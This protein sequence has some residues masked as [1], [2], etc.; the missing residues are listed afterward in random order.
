MHAL[1]RQNP[2]LLREVLASSAYESII[3]VQCYWLLYHHSACLLWHNTTSLSHRCRRYRRLPTR[4]PRHSCTWRTRRCWSRRECTVHLHTHPHLE[5]QQ[6]SVFICLTPQKQYACLCVCVCLC[7]L[8]RPAVC[9]EDKAWVTGAGIRSGDISA[10]L[11]A[12]TIATF[13]NIWCKKKKRDK[14]VMKHFLATT[15]LSCFYCRWPEEGAVLQEE[16]WRRQTAALSFLHYPTVLSC[17][18][19]F[20]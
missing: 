20:I 17:N 5:E 14:L 16:S 9:V 12:V 4:I 18:V 15:L 2:W 10:Q 11:L 19:V 7:T 8:T 1:T 3:S 6:G 13:I